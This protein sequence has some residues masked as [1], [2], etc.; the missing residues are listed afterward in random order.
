MLNVLISLI[1]YLSS[2]II[3]HTTPTVRLANDT[4]WPIPNRYCHGCECVDGFNENSD[5]VL[6]PATPHTRCYVTINGDCRG[7]SVILI[8]AQ[9]G[10]YCNGG[11]LY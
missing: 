11:I 8:P 5:C 10:E 6:E 2:H 1:F 9:P 3:P 7:C 4:T